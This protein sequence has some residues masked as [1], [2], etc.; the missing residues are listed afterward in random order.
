MDK[1]G[2]VDKA[3]AV[4][5][6]LHT[7]GPSS[8]AGIGSRL[9]MARPTV[10]RLLATLAAHDLV[11]RDD[12]GRWQLGAGLLRLASGM[13]SQEPLVAAA[14]PALETAA[15]A[16]GETFFVVA[17]RAGRLF[18][19]D[20]VEGNGLLRAT[21]QIGSEV[22]LTTT[23]SGRLYL[24]LAPEAVAAPSPM[25]ASLRDRIAT[26]AKR[27]WDVNDGEWQAE[28]SVV[29]AAVGYSGD[30][31]SAVPTRKTGMLRPAPLVGT[32][33]CACAASTLKG[34]RLDE[35]VRHTR[36]AA[37][38]IANALISRGEPEFTGAASAKGNGK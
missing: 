29:A 37:A 27:G 38:D 10:H 17:A 24:G 31:E 32:V 16:F 21:P 36:Q 1:S 34:A 14:R 9:D 13:L 6:S 7:A 2:T 5:E 19:L 4:L 28:L 23:A 3:I 20:R 8:V 26:A 11:N 12:Q 33:A 22:P 35:A 18:I 25:T 30:T 15:S